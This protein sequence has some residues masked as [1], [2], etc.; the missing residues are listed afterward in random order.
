MKYT[1]GLFLVRE[2]TGVGIDLMLK[3]RDGL[4]Q[5]FQLQGG[6]EHVACALKNQDGAGDA[7]EK[8]AEGKDLVA[9]GGGPAGPGGEDLVGM[10]VVES[11]ALLEL[12]AGIGCGHLLDEFV[13]CAG[14]DDEGALENEGA[15]A[16]GH[17]GVEERDAGAFAVAVENGVGDGKVIEEL[18]DDRVDLAEV[19][20]VVALG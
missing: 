8:V 19:V 1:V 10:L 4:L 14:G 2:V 17:C 7:G 18:G 9:E 3:T 16:R 6:A 13:G 12:A 20:G 11:E 5:C 15:D